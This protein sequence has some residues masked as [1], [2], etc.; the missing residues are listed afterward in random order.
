MGTVYK[1]ACGY[2][3]YE[4]YWYRDRNMAVGEITGHIETG[5]E[6]QSTSNYTMRENALVTIAL[7]IG[8]GH[9]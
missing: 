9:V 5:H 2:C 8:T 6:G 3:S 1:A 4:T 7:T